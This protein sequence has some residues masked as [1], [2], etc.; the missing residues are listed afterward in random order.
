MKIIDHD[1]QHEALALPYRKIILGGT[2]DGLHEGHR[3]LLESAFAVSETV[4]IGVTSDVYIDKSSKTLKEL[5]LD[6]KTRMENLA[7]YL[8]SFNLLNRAMLI[9]IDNPYP[10]S[11]YDPQLEAIIVTSDSREGGETV[12]LKRLEAGLGELIIIEIGLV[13]DQSGEVVS[14]TRFR[15]KKVAAKS[16]IQLS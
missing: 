10:N 4:L 13:H 5:I 16:I 3:L 2:F 7:T 11:I 1:P 9:P 14:S 12:N 8:E 15:Q 6:C